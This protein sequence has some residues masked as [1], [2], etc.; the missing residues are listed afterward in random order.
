MRE[1][2]LA[3]RQQRDVEV[4]G[5]VATA[6][7]A[8]PPGAVAVSSADVARA[9][10]DQAVAARDSGSPAVQIDAVVVFL[11]ILWVL[12]IALPPVVVLTLPVTAQ[13]IIA[14]YVAAVGNA[15]IITWRVSDNRKHD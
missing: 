8:A 6:W 10:E 12:T 5:S 15:L 2:V 13:A 14:G 3:F 4:L 7:A 9:T 1:L 11:A